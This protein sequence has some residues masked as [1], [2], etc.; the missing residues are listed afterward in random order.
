MQIIDR[1]G[2][3]TVKL[4]QAESRRLRDAAYIARRAAINLMPA[5]D[6]LVLLLQAAHDALLELVGLG[7]THD[8]TAKLDREDAERPPSGSSR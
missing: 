4:T 5:D 7:T 3:V 6:P 2:V 1:G 8:N